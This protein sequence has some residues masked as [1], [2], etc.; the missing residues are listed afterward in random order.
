MLPTVFSI[1]QPL[2]L[3]DIDQLMF[4]F[5]QFRQ[6]SS[7]VPVDC[8]SNTK[9]YH[10]EFVCNSVSYMLTAAFVLKE[11]YHNISRMCPIVTMGVRRRDKRGHIQ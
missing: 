8:V 3:S 10:R 9:A 1:S 11:G 5:C 7:T 6:K 2:Q 4:T